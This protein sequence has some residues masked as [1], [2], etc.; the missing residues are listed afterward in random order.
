MKTSNYLNLLVIVVLFGFCNLSC[1]RVSS[2]KAETTPLESESVNNMN[3]SFSRNFDVKPER[4]ENSIH[5]R[6]LTSI[7]YHDDI[8]GGVSG[9]DLLLYKKETIIPPNIDEL[10]NKIAISKYLKDQFIEINKE[11]VSLENSYDVDAPIQV[12]SKDGS[13]DDLLTIGHKKYS[14]A[15]AIVAFSRVA[16]NEDKSKALVYAEFY[17]K[18]VEIKKI[19]MTLSIKY[20]R[21][22]K[23]EIN[24]DVQLKDFTLLN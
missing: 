18:K 20:W 22:G 16:Y 5:A 19:L 17:S 1:Q 23:D 12:L 4:L 7:F 11:K 21:V 6:L 3:E 14:R 10:E 24:F 15:I 2:K 8:V 13:L 9:N